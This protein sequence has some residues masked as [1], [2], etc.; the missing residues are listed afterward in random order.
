MAGEAGTR[1]SV[2]DSVMD[3]AVPL[4]HDGN[5]TVDY[6]VYIAD[7][8]QEISDLSWRFSRSSCRR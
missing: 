6:I 5:G 2:S 1:S 8:K 7:D 4:D 3:I